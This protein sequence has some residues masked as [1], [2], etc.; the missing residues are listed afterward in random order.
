MTVVWNAGFVRGSKTRQRPGDNGDKT[1]AE[2]GLSIVTHWKKLL[3][4]LRSYTTTLAGHI[5]EARI[6]DMPTIALAF[7]VEIVDGSLE[8]EI[9]GQLSEAIRDN[10]IEDMKRYSLAFIKARAAARIV[11]GD[12]EASV[13][14]AGITAEPGPDAAASCE[15]Q[16]EGITRAILGDDYPFE[17]LHVNHQHPTGQAFAGEKLEE[18]FAGKL[19][20]ASR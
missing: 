11:R 2:N 13:L 17:F 1:A 15:D 4:R 10:A 18:S 20:R 8:R 5:S 19:N 16:F 9:C 6:E 14:F 12:H 7:R 3:G